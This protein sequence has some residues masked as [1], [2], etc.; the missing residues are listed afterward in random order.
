MV[1]FIRYGGNAT[2]FSKKIDFI[3]QQCG[4]DCEFVALDGPISL[5]SSEIPPYLLAKIAVG[6][7][8]NQFAGRPPLQ[9]DYRAW[10]LRGNPETIIEY[11]KFIITFM[12][13]Q[14]VPFDGVLGFS[15]G[16]AAAALLTALLEHPEFISIITREQFSIW[17]PG[18]SDAPHPPLKFCIAVAG[19][20]PR[21]LRSLD[22]LF[23]RGVNTPTLHII[24]EADQLVPVNL[25]ETLV[26][27]C[28]NSRVEKHNG[29][30]IIPAGMYWGQF[31]ARYISLQDHKQSAA[32]PSPGSSVPAP[33][34][35][36][37]RGSL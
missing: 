25:A 26:Q 19:F 29:G 10:W 24:G 36:A 37:F 3:R 1:D 16:A 32:V 28:H 30:H 21:S 27:V 14:S 35:R 31:I 18:S 17:A 13:R 15:N 23:E 33:A 11:V 22:T 12:N 20:R 5:K 7:R 2:I 8:L 4:N 9:I 6:A 34:F